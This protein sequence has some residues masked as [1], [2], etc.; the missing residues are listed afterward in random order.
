MKLCR[1]L[2]VVVI[3]LAMHAS[4]FAGLPDGANAKSDA[5]RGV[6]PLRKHSK[7]LAQ[8]YTDAYGI[9]GKD[10]ACSRF[11]GGAAA[12]TAFEQLAAQLRSGMLGNNLVGIRMSGHVSF[13]KNP[14]KVSYRIFEEVIINAS[15]PFY[16]AAAFPSDPFIPNVGSFRPNTREARVLMLLH[17][18]A[19]LVVGPEG[20]WLIPD[21]ANKPEQN[22]RNTALVESRCREEIL[23]L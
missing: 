2:F 16:K 15:G 19:H 6:E 21:D 14:G 3:C 17:E 22:N 9:L 11:F 23:S 4:T 8:A 5:P 18:L 13:Y 7:P 12:Q 20:K 1:R 10:N